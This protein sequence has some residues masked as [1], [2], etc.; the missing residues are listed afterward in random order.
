MKNWLPAVSASS[1]FFLVYKDT[2]LPPNYTSV[3]RITGGLDVVKYVAAGGV[4]PGSSDAS[5]GPPA[6]PIVIKTAEI[7]N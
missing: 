3:G 6:Q 1:Q 5:D 4:E 7:E 2:T